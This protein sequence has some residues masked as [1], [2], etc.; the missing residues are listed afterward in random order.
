M[1]GLEKNDRALLNGSLIAIGEFGRNAKKAIPQILKYLDDK[2]PLVRTYACEALG[3]IQEEPEIVVPRIREKLN[4][5]DWLVVE[6]AKEALLKLPRV[7][8][9]I[10]GE[11]I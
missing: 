6:A 1:C 11:Y 8:E 10:I 3:K 7:Q 9:P 4:D 5:P 2:D